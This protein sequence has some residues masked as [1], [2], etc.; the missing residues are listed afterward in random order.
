LPKICSGFELKNFAIKE[1]SVAR[2]KING[3]IPNSGNS[4]LLMIFPKTQSVPNPFGV[5][6][7][8]NSNIRKMEQINPK[9]V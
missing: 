2:P 1:V 4:K 8:D 5:C 3:A 9:M 6:N 7:I